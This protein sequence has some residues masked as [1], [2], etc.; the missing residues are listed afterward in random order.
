[1]ASLP[2]APSLSI[3]AIRRLLGHPAP[4]YHS[5]H[6]PQQADPMVCLDHFVPP[7]LTK[8]SWCCVLALVVNAGC[9]HPLSTLKTPL[10]VCALVGG[11]LTQQFRFKTLERPRTVFHTGCTSQ[12]CI[13]GRLP[14]FIFTFLLFLPWVS[15]DVC[16]PVWSKS[17]VQN[18]SVRDSDVLRGKLGVGGG[19]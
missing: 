5:L 1:M 2:L 10:A 15:L 13:R 16:L 4:S 6:C 18:Y 17:L 7:P 3:V 19:S 11:L 9:K 8:A 14:P 12:Q